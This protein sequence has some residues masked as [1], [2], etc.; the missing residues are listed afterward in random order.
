MKLGEND[1]LV[2][3]AF[4]DRLPIEFSKTPCN[5][6]RPAQPV[7]AD[8]TDVLND[9]LDLSSDEV[10]QGEEAGHFV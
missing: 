1:P 4:A 7:G 3:E 9:W 5:T 6:Y 8:N 2:G 10:R